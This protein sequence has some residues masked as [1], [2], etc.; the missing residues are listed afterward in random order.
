MEEQI[1][2][3]ELLEEK[4][5]Y[6]LNVKKLRRRLIISSVSIVLAI[7]TMFMKKYH[8]FD[9]IFKAYYSMRYED[10]VVTNNLGSMGFI[11]GFIIALLFV[12]FLWV[13][14]YNRGTWQEK[15]SAKWIYDTFDIISILPVFIA[16]VTILNAFVISPA[17]V[18]RTSMEPN[19]YE[20][21]NVFIL[22]TRSYE[23][24]D[25]VI[26][27]AGVGEYNPATGRYERNDYYIKRVIGLPGETVKIEGGEIYIDGV[28]LDD[29]TVLKTGAGTYC[30]VGYS[31]D[32]SQVCT[33]TIPE[34]EYFLIGDNR[35]ASYD[36]RA[37]G[38]FKEEDLYGKVILKIS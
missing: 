8:D 14:L 27:L 5:E 30:D 26:V 18:T 34:G 36:S 3:E 20:G 2:E 22:H 31:V 10:Y 23:R 37:L 32:K 29:P 13:F 25:V 17:T 1:I 12:V 35:E 9:V 7:I 11:I 38:P 4:E 21:D 24:Y 19:Y 33:F 28:L 6:S 16:L 15:V